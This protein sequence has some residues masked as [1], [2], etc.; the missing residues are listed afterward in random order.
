MQ[1]LVETPWSG[2]DFDTGE[3]E[4]DLVRGVFRRIRAVDRV[5]FDR[6]GEILADRAGIGLFR[7]RGA[8]N[9]AIGSDSTLAL[10]DLGHDRAGNHEA[11]Q[12]AEERAGLMDGVEGFSLGFG[13]L[14]ALLSDDLEALFLE[15]RIDLAGEVPPGR[16][17]LDD[18]QG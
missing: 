10:E 18:R 5:R 4:R 3:E 8:H 13:E 9:V 11:D 16:V 1:P 6:F 2:G 17:R 15:P 14:E 12:L 7:V